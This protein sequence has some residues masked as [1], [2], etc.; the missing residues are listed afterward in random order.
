MHRSERRV[1]AAAH[2][3]PSRRDP[4]PVAPAPIAA[5]LRAVAGRVRRLGLAGRFDPEAAYVERDELAQ[6]LL[7][8]AVEADGANGGQVSPRPPTIAER[9]TPT[10]KRLLALLAVRQSEA[11]HL[12]TLL[13]QAMRPARR[14]RRSPG[15]GQLL[16][17]IFGDRP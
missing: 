2:S 3:R 14:S 13:A 10:V 9:D 7:R 1:P 12:K 5:R 4:A 16:L 8:L 15:Q 6:A 11:E 17:P